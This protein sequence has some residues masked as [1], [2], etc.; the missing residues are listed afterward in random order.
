MHP[1]A[2]EISEGQNHVGIGR[3]T[4][5]NDASTVLDLANLLGNPAVRSH[6]ARVRPEALLRKASNFRELC[7]GDLFWRR[8]VGDDVAATPIARHSAFVVA[9]LQW[10]GLQKMWSG[11]RAIVGAN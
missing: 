3:A 1:F 4:Q 6:R 11:R 10:D 9:V 7:I 8:L 2:H 5:K